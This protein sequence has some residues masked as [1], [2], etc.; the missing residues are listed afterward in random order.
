MSAISTVTTSKRLSREQWDDYRMEAEDDL[1]TIQSDLLELADIC[2]EEIDDNSVLI[3][4]DAYADEIERILA[5]A[6]DM[7]KKYVYD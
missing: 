3:D 1:S 6:K 2:Q 4:F 7:A 5:K